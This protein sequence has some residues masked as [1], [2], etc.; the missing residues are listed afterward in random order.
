MKLTAEI[1]RQLL[2]YD[3]ETGELT[4]KPRG[5]HWFA[6]ESAFKSWNTKYAGKKGV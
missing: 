4:W 1:A 6:S 5:S 2:D 3:P